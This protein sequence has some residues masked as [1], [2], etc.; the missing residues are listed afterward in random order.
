MRTLF[1]RRLQSPGP[2]R[3]GHKDSTRAIGRGSGEGRDCEG[4]LRQPQVG[5]MMPRPGGS[6]WPSASALGTIYSTLKINSA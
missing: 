2:D 3:H 5:T 6:L 4:K 1:S